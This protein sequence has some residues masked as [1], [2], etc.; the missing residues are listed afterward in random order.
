[1]A[2]DMPDAVLNSVSP[3]LQ[4]LAFRLSEV[5]GTC[6]DLSDDL[7][8]TRVSVQYGCPTRTIYYLFGQ[9]IARLRGMVWKARA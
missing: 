1:M 5:K 6:H 2:G 9:D 4:F 8:R 7:S 3:V